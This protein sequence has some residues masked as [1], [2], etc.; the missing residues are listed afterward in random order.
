[1]WEHL[2]TLI[3]MEWTMNIGKGIAMPMWMMNLVGVVGFMLPVFAQEAKQSPN[4]VIIMAD[5]L[6]YGDL[7]CYGATK[8]HTPHTD[9][10]AENGARFTDA[11][12]SSSLCSP[13]RYSLM[14][15]RYSWRTPLR[16]GV[17]K[18]FAKPLTAAGQ[19]TLGSVLQHK[20]YHTAYVGKWHLGFEWA[21]RDD[22]LPSDPD[23]DVFDTWELTSQS[24][25]D[26]SKPVG[27]GP[28]TRGFNHYYGISASNN[29]IPFVFIENDRVVLPPTVEKEYVYD[30]DQSSPRAA[31]WDLETLDQHLTQQAT[32]LIDSHFALQQRAPLFLMFST[33]SIHRPCLPTF[34]KGK[35]GAGIRGDMVLEFDWIVGQVVDALK[36]NGA[37]EN[38]FLIVTSDNGAVP[39][40]PLVALERYRRDLGDRYY[41]DYFD[42]Y[43]PQYADPDGNA[44]NQKGWLTYDHAAAGPFRGFK[45]DAWE[46]GHRIPLVMHWPGMVA[47]GQVNDNMVCNVD[48]MATL[49]DV[50]GYKGPLGQD[51]YSFWSNLTG[52]S[53]DQVRT[54]MVLVSGRSGAYAV[55]MDNWKYIEESDRR[56]NQGQTHYA[57]GPGP[58][59]H[60]LYNLAED[61]GERNNLYVR[62]PDI[63][64]D[65]K[66]LIQNIE[67]A[68]QK[69]TKHE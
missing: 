18:W 10:L 63:V 50:V 62:K 53:S 60:Q 35:S 15:G 48:L 28:T 52:K 11:H 21:L 6:G 1:M 30:T 20:G 56:W 51:S 42:D 54:S 58:A 19:V 34:T 39:G 23:R 33:A 40:D 13:S 37:F 26:F 14:T 57:D 36:R 9:R 8:I 64:A 24:H 31:N 27:Q 12:S 66:Q 41:L 43:A 45:S 69:E 38:T 4:I 25:I 7:S 5:D 68:K 59:D 16:R 55:R 2:N 49:A 17:L 67:H 65:F 29:M 47:S 44:V 22:N 46:G 61:T 32:R 3:D